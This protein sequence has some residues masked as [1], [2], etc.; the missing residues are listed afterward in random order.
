VV[1]VRQGLVEPRAALAQVIAGRPEVRERA[2]DPQLE[3]GRVAVA[4]PVERR[5]EVVVLGLEVLPR[6]AVAARRAARG[7]WRARSDRARRAAAR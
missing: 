5:A 4:A 1:G 7:S 6:R 3:L 2:G